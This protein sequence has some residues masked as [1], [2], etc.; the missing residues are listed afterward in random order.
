MPSECDD[1]DPCTDEV[2]DAERGCAS[3]PIPGCELV[4][5]NGLVQQSEQ[6]DDGNTSDGDGCSSSCLIEAGPA[7]D[8]AIVQA[9]AATEQVID[10]YQG[11]PAG[12]CAGL[13]ESAIEKWNRGRAL[14][15]GDPDHR[16]VKR[17]MGAA[18]SGLSRLRS[19]RRRCDEFAFAVAV[20]QIGESL[21][22]AVRDIA[23]ATAERVACDGNSRCERSLA[24]AEQRI[25]K[26][27]AK[28]ALGKS[29]IA[30]SR[31]RSA[32]SLA[33]RFLD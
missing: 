8:Q 32:Y 27:D 6:C 22:L 30:L 14:L 18:K 33:V 23:Q 20:A 24:R 9:I 1:G 21:A 11:E 12:A 16:A 13:L 7:L 17:A 5:G 26:G 3:V 15:T 31:Y 2:C 19:A 10:D 29:R 25:A 28:L 4:C